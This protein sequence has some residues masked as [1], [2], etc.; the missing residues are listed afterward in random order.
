VRKRGYGTGNKGEGISVET[1]GDVD[2]G[3][4]CP[5]NQKRKAKA[6]LKSFDARGKRGGGTIGFWLVKG[7]GRRSPDQKLCRKDLLRLNERALDPKETVNEK[8]AGHKVLGPLT[9]VGARGKEKKCDQTDRIPFGREGVQLNPTP[10]EKHE[11]GE[12][13][14][15]MPTTVKG[16]VNGL[17]V[18]VIARRRS[19][20]KEVTIG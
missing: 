2:E 9:K 11:R 18:P 14:G 7:R 17:Q 19:A 6:F 8:K 13:E 3:I 12:I 20:G 15:V 4:P 5:G 16:E 1:R 10:E